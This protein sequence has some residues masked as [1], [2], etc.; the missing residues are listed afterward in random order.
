MSNLP[1]TARLLS[2]TMSETDLPTGA[3]PPYVIDGYYDD[4]SDKRL[5]IY[6]AQADRFDKEQSESWKGGTEEILVFVC[7]RVA[8]AIR[9]SVPLTFLRYV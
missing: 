6:L 1:Q 4:P 8:C 9:S 3:A 5:S 7:H 2:P